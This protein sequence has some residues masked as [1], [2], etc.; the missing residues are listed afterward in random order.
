MK[1]LLLTAATGCYIAQSCLAGDF[2]MNNNQNTIWKIEKSAITLTPGGKWQDHF[3]MSGRKVDLILEWRV[4]ESLNF[5]ANRRI[6]F[7]MLRTIP[8]NT[9]HG[10]LIL[11]SPG[12][13][14]YIDDLEFR[15]FE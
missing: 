3:A 9:R 10:L 5:H 13:G 11:T 7:P 4:D 6:R 1:K 8:D 12:N 2:S 14:M 15:I